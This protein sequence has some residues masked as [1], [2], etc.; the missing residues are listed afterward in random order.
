ME[1]FVRGS[2]QA[3]IVKL[4]QGLSAYQIPQL[5]MFVPMIA[6]LCPLPAIT[7]QATQMTSSSFSTHSLP[8]LHP[9][10]M[11]ETASA[12]AILHLLLVSTSFYPLVMLLSLE[13]YEKKV[14]P[15]IFKP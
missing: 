10:P 8:A 14:I 11:K 13:K 5:K 6:M 15:Q 1:M 7:N 4:Q 2:L 12:K 9:V 3:R